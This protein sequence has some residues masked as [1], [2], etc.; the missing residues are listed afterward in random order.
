MNARAEPVR[1]PSHVP[2]VNDGPEPPIRSILLREAELGGVGRTLASGG[3]ATAPRP[4]GTDFARRTSANAAEIARVVRGTEKARARGEQITPAANWLLDNHYV[5]QDAV[6]QI[7]RALPR[8]FV[9]QLPLMRLADGAE[10]PRALAIAWA[11]V[12]HTDSAASSTGFEALVRGFQEVEPLRIGELWA[13]PS[14]LRFVLIENLARMARRVQHARDMRAAANTLADRIMATGDGE[15]L[16]TLTAHR[17]KARDIIFATQL[18]FR[19]RCT[20]SRP[21]WSAPAPTPSRPPCASMRGFRP[22][23]SPSPTSSAA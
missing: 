15:A 7:R 21:S 5:V 3:G 6:R 2:S 17:E 10:V 1:P 19:L 12:A 18:L 14:L 8:G 9:R 13:L 16:Q 23:T 11:Y 4:F 22:A 20:G